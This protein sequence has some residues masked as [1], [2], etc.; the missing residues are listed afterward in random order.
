MLIHNYS[1]DTGEFLNSVEPR[2]SPNEPGDSLTPAFATR[3]APPT[4]VPAGSVAVFLNLDGIPPSD[5]GAGDWVLKSDL[6]GQ[7][8]RTVD[9]QP[10]YLDIPGVQPADM[11]LTDKEP[12][13]LVK[14][15]D[16]DWVTDV[17]KLTLSVKAKRNGLLAVASMQMAPLSD[18]VDLNIAT[19]DEVSALSQWRQ[20]RVDLSR[21]ET[22]TGFPADVAWPLAP[23]ESPPTSE[24]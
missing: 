6:R 22:Q 16:G 8:W 5:G 21:I 3:T 20:Y 7:Y 23:G 10:V 9:A 13:G 19:S 18:A 24:S 17:D 14:W 12:I 4:D 1:G 15:L 2:V 11:G